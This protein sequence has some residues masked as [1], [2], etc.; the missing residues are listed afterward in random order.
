MKNK[1]SKVQTCVCVQVRNDLINHNH[2][3]IYCNYMQLCYYNENDTTGN[4]SNHPNHLQSFAGQHQQ[5]F[6]TSNY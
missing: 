1:S 3:M 6:A 5:G 4:K 2:I